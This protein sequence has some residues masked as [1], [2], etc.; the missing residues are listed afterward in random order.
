MDTLEAFKAGKI[1][2][3]VCS[4]VAARGLDI[5]AMSHVFNFDVPTS[6]DDYV[7]RIGRT[8][9]A[10]RKGKA[11]TIATPEDSRYLGSIKRLTGTDIPRIDLDGITAAKVEDD[12]SGRDKRRRNGKP[13]RPSRR[14]ADAKRENRPAQ[15][16]RKRDPGDR[17]RERSQNAAAA[18][19]QKPASKSSSNGPKP[20]GFGD[21]VPAF[22]L[23]S[24]KTG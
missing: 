15:S 2:F 24:F 17:Q 12:D 20:V 4:D 10:G 6:A 8:G 9:R 19:A 5:Q 16:G 3:L 18:P 13:E 22:L 11:I 7:H 21:D 1:K 23:R 14:D